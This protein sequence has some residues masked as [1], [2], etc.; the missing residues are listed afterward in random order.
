MG[1]YLPIKKHVRAQKAFTLVE[2]LVVIAIIGVLIGLL[3]PAV[4]AA[5]EA[6]RRSVCTNNIRQLG[7]AM[8]QHHEAKKK[9]PIGAWP[10]HRN[11][12]V[13]V[14]P[15][16]EEAGLYAT[17]NLNPKG[18][19]N[20]S[21]GSRRYYADE[22]SLVK[23]ALLALRKDTLQCPSSKF[24]MTNPEHLPA[25]RSAANSQVGQVMDYVGIAGASPDPAERSG[26]CT[27][28]Q[29]GEYCKTGMLGVGVPRG[30]SQCTDGTTQTILLAEQS[31]QVNGREISANAYAGWHGHV[32]NVFTDDNFDAPS[33]SAATFSA[34]IT[35]V[36]HRPN[37][38][39]VSGAASGAENQ[40]SLNTVINSFH[41]GG[42]NVVFADGSV[43]FLSDQID[44]LTLRQLC[45]R[46]DGMTV[47]SEY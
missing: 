25:S 43:R 26:V 2:L 27:S 13:D 20:A 9:F 30:I 45:C 4:Q 31:G 36:R 11:W 16:I 12:R 32:N 14:L 47:A 38:Y 21:T 35:T 33:P 5:R 29:Y 18:P 8:H 41:P 6:G 46:D 7:L 22:L 3:L 37:S 24:G 42:I 17:L 28:A 39:W 40:E 10:D 23:P 19:G 1:I 34:G 44:F 15:F